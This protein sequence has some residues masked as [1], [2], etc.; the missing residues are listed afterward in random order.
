MISPAVL[1]VVSAESLTTQGHRRFL[2]RRQLLL[3]LLEEITVV[4]L[5][6]GN[7]QHG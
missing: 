2:L 6:R 7:G 5:F 3:V 1:R 4:L